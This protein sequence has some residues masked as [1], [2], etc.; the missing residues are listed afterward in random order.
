MDEITDW[1]G[2][3]ALDIIL[4][5]IG[6]YLVQFVVFKLT[7][8]IVSRSLSFDHKTNARDHVLRQNTIV[9]IINSLLLFAIWFVVIILVLEAIGVD[10][11]ALLAGAGVVSIAIGFGAK[12]LV[13]DYIAGMFIVIENQYRVGDVVKL[14]STG[15]RVEAITLR[16]TSLRD[17]DGNIHHI[18]NG[19]VQV[20]TNKTMDYSK[21]NMNISVSYDSD[22]EKV[23]KVVNEVGV[24][25]YKDV[26]WAADIIDPPRFLRITSFGDSAVIIKI[27]GKTAPER[28]W[29]VAGELRKRIKKAFDKKGITIPFPQVVVHQS[30]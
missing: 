24:E 28:Q 26:E 10:A 20:I 17:L 14:D 3:H 29:A 13:K 21:I 7:K 4:I 6:A 18:A 22:I 2:N 12:D 27:V 11:K 25:L 15:G 23:E 5:L 9:G 30:K 19:N 1:F 16:T 8:F